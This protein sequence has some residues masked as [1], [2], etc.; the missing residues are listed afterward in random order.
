MSQ[1]VVIVGAGQAGVQTAVSLRAQGFGGKITLVCQEQGL[2]YQKPPLSKAF[3]QG[4]TTEQSILLKSL[5]VYQES[6]IELLGGVCVDA[7]DPLERRLKLS[8]GEVLAYNQ[9]VLATGARSRSLAVPGAELRGVLTLR[10]LSDAKA[11]VSCIRSGGKVVVIGAG[12]IGLEFAAVARELG[13]EVSVVEAGPRALGRALSSEMAMHLQVEH[14]KQGIKFFF[15]ATIESIQGEDHVEYVTLTNGCRLD[16]DLVLIGIGV[17]PNTEL[18]QRAGLKVDDGIIV[19]RELRT[20]DQHIFA[21]GDCA[22]H[23]NRFSAVGNVRLESVQNATDQ[24]I[25]LASRLAGKLSEYNAVP[26]FWSDQGNLKLQIAGLVQGYDASVVRGDP[27]S[28]SFSVFCFLG[29]RLLGVE[30]LNHR[31]D[32]ILARRL[33]AAGVQVTQSEVADEGVSLKNYLNAA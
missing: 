32:H 9:L 8:T 7:I 16:A 15:D 29:K 13:M 10:T 23:P 20:S 31:T 4:R 30:T 6:A 3:L 24:A 27:A 25:C 14:L 28:G 17:T 18:A 11:L 5:S 12:F 33:L 22:M 1:T 21:I 26:W 19:D 2:P